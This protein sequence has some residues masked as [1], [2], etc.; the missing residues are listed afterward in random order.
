MRGARA[1]RRWRQ[2]LWRQVDGVLSSEEAAQLRAHIGGCPGCRM[3]Y[4]LAGRLDQVLASSPSAVPA[5]GFQERVMLGVAAG[6][7]A[8]APLPRRTRRARESSGE[9]GDWW[10]LL[11]GLGAALVVVVISISVLSQVTLRAVSY[12]VSSPTS[13]ASA[14]AEGLA[15]GFQQGFSVSGDTLTGLTQSPLAFGLILMG[16]IVAI[17]IGWLGLSLSRSSAS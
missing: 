11:G 17:T 10:V 2:A 1:C 13:A 15:R 3:V 14:F 6:L 9:A 8:G 7:K 5:E 16:G 4:E 12:A